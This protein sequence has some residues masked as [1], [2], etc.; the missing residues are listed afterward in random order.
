MRVLAAVRDSVR[1]QRCG[2]MCAI[3][4]WIHRNE[5]REKESAR[6]MKTQQALTQTGHIPRDQTNLC[7][8]SESECWDHSQITLND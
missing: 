1:E 7:I 5:N 6:G 2:R 3:L 8:I 4:S